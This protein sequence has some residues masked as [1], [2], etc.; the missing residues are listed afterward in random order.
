MGDARWSRLEVTQVDAHSVVLGARA[1]SP[2][3]LL[4]PSN[5]GRSAWVF[6]SSYGGG[7]VGADDV[8]LE[9]QVRAGATLFLS[10]QASSKAYR[11]ADARLELDATLEAGAVLV[12]WPDPTVCF[13]QAS[14]AQ[15]QRFAL[16][17]QSA[18]LVALEQV[19]SGRM[20]RAE[21][22]QFEAYASRLRLDVGGAA[23]L[24]EALVLSQAHGELAARLGALDALATV[25]IA[26][27]PCEALAASVEALVRS[28]PL[29]KELL[30]VC[31]RS[32]GALVLRA[33]SS[34]SAALTGRLRELL[35][36]GV[37]QLLG[38]DPL[39]RKW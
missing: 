15:T 30:V 36:P 35:G 39:R 5:H 13:A 38:D 7:F 23:A 21:R 20:A 9:V 22:W 2:L 3:K 26:G 11:Q 6:Q 29:S 28:A 34:S 17:D 31:S 4:N 12:S 10:S 33:A 25:V 37:A 1:V 27:A 19:T 14:F 24:R 8:R 32:A 18:G 16:A